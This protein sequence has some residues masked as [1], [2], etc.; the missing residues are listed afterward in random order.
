MAG[1]DLSELPDQ[2]D[3][4]ELPDQEEP[5]KQ[6]AGKYDSKGLLQRAYEFVTPSIGLREKGVDLRGDAQLEIPAISN[7]FN[8][9]ADKLKPQDPNADVMLN[10]I[11][12]IGSGGMRLLGGILA[13]GFDP[14]AVFTKGSDI[15]SLLPKVE[16]PRLALPAGRRVQP[17]IIEMRG[18][19]PFIAGPAGNPLGQA[20]AHDV[21]PD[22]AARISGIAIPG[23]GELIPPALDT[24]LVREQNRLKN[25]M[26]GEHEQAGLQRLTTP[27]RPPMSQP[28]ESGDTTLGFA[29]QT[30]PEKSLGYPLDIVPNRLRPRTAQSVT[31]ATTPNIFKRLLKD[32][33]GS[34]DIQKLYS[35][36][37]KRVDTGLTREDFES[38]VAT[39]AA[40]TE[41]ILPSARAAKIDLSKI[42]DQAAAP[43]IPDI[44]A[45]QLA[46]QPQSVIQKLTAAIDEGIIK[47]KEQAKS[48]TKERAG[49][50][51]NLKSVTTPGEKG[52]YQQL[53]TLKGEYEKLG[54]PP[55]RE[56]L[57]QKDIDSVV[58]IIS[59][60]PVG[61]ELTKIHA[62]SGL[63]K[64]LNGQ[65]PQPSELK[66][67]NQILGTAIDVPGVAKLPATPSKLRQIYELTRGLKSVD[68]P[69]MTSAAFRQGSGLF[70][71]REWL[72]AFKDQAR[73]F[74]SERVYDKIMEG[75]EANPIHQKRVIATPLGQTEFASIADQIGLATSDLKSLSSRDEQIRGII[76]EKIPGLGRWIRGSNR[77]YTAFINSL[78]TATAE[79]W[80]KAA[81]LIDGQ[82]RITNVV[83]ASKIA[84]TINE[85]TGAGSLRIAAPF[86]RFTKSGR[87]LNLQKSADNLSLLFFSP[88]LMVRDARMMNPLNY[89]KNDK[90]VRLKYLEGAVRRAGMWAGF[91]TLGALAGADVSDN[92]LSSDFGK[93]KMG[94]TRADA[95]SGLLQWIV[96]TARQ[97]AGE[98]TS[99]TSGRTREFGSNAVASTRKD[100]ALDFLINRLHPSL[101]PIA[102]FAAATKN[103]P[104]YPMSEAGESVTPFPVADMIELMKHDPEMEQIILGLAASG[105]SM[106]SM[107]YGKSDFGKPTFEVPGDVK[108]EGGSL[109]PR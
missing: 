74:S 12:G 8:S 26:F 40:R 69:F 70:G 102:N 100:L 101:R 65:I 28:A 63:V 82:G 23:K 34:L 47:A 71:T 46:A 43:K 31:E 60:A 9:M 58:D 1:I 98:S 50:F 37:K 73:S 49:R 4:S 67:L 80:L 7:F 103:R 79:N 62:K 87:E 105:L 53:G 61:D 29:E 107:T 41:D 36:W 32:E 25:L 91:T 83:E 5:A 59:A 99:S 55:L 81:N 42:P 11:R 72:K 94:D 21:P 93:V 48:Y 6:T 56:V 24:E 30:N 78:R 95:G 77:S 96:L 86:S 92:P 75:V 104:F 3:L 35:E 89:M 68:V 108:F 14:S 2:I 54:M 76:A 90:L 13:T 97:A 44:P 64:L 18:D 106:G 85:L 66:I 45:E 27:E 51:A 10:N 39:Q 22:I 16:S 84:N 19:T 20:A 109:I 33:E 88:K 17:D 38:Y 52:F 15:M 57:D